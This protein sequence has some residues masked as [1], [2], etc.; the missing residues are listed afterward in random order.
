MKNEKQHKARDLYIH[1]A[2]NQV[3]IAKLLEIDRKTLYLWIRNNQWEKMKIAA[4]QAPSVIKQDIFNHIDAINAKIYSR[5]DCYPTMQEVEMMR[6]LIVMSGNIDRQ[7]TGAY[8]DAFQDLVAFIHKRDE[9][10]AIEV[11]GHADD[12][13][14]ANLKNSPMTSD[15]L[16]EVEAVIREEEL[17]AQKQAAKQI[18]LG[19]GIPGSAITTPNDIP[20][21]NNG[22]LPK[23]NDKSPKPATGAANSD[24]TPTK[25]SEKF[26]ASGFPPHG[27]NTEDRDPDNT[28]DTP[29]DKDNKPG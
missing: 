10:L 15:V 17:T 18:N 3:E 19:D 9:K 2:L 29:G 14:K 27:E 8:L 23:D 26:P 16:T 20:T 7:H 11:V 1:S 21:G 25:D 24:P 4:R 5:E 12:F 22:E 6:K 28:N 13:V